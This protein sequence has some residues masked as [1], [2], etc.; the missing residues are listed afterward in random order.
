MNTGD[1]DYFY[2]FYKNS[3]SSIERIEK[4]LLR[5]SYSYDKWL[6]TLQEKSKTLRELYEKNEIGI[7]KVIEAFV[8]KYKGDEIENLT[9]P[10]AEEY[11]T[12]VDFFLSEGYRDYEVTVPVLKTLIRFYE[13]KGP[14]VR[15]LDCYYFYAVAML[16]QREFSEAQRYFSEVIAM[17][18]NAN[19][20]V[21]LYR[22]FRIMCSHYFR[23]LAAICED[24]LAQGKI[25]TYQNSAWQIWTVL[26]PIDFLN[27]RQRNAIASILRT[28]PG[29]TVLAVLQEKKEVLP[30]LFRIVE[31]EYQSQ[32][33]GRKNDLSVDSLIYLC[34]YKANFLH[35]DYTKK[36]YLR[37][38][39]KKFLHEKK[40]ID[41][42]YEYGT[43][44][45]IELF[46]DEL[47]EERVAKENL[48]YMN[49][50][51]SFV[52]FLIPEILEY[53]HDEKIRKTVYEELT[54]YYGGIPV[55]SGDFLTDFRIEGQ[56]K[57]LFSKEK[58]VEIVLGCLENI[59]VSR[60]VTT[61]IHSGM[62]SRLATIMTSRFIESS[63]DLFVGQCGTTC[64]E[65]VLQKKDEI[66][67]FAKLA[68][69]CHDYGKIWCS[70]IINLQER[71][72]VD[73]EFCM[74]KR[75]SKKGAEIFESIE[76]LRPFRDIAIG[77]HKFYD[78]SYG[79]PSHFDNV[80]SPVKIFIDII[81]LCDCIDAVTD[82]LGRNYAVGKDFY[83]VLKEF[84][85]YSGSRYS[86][87]LVELIG[88]DTEL[89]KQIQELT[90]N[91]RKNVYYE[92]YNKY[93][94]ADVLFRP[95]NEKIVRELRESDVYVVGKMTGEAKKII[96]ERM[97]KCEVCY[98][99][100]DGF[101]KIFGV[102]YAETLQDALW[103]RQIQVAES[104][105]RQ[106]IGSMLYRYLEEMVKNNGGGTIYMPVVVEGH[107]DKFCWRNGFVDSDV[108]GYMV[109]N[110]KK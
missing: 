98:L 29:Y 34:H 22:K 89:Q 99:V 70:D 84:E 43:M 93:V 57:R 26:P 69:R 24:T 35:G 94:K 7:K 36:E 105:R 90:I 81:T 60:Q 73:E 11:L 49:P 64:E 83:M 58:D 79:Y 103:I 41:G 55:N 77:H 85:R 72:I 63:P 37:I 110:V 17:F 8:D 50:G 19:M 2:N 76:A 108:E 54:T 28:L 82:K 75:H 62:V 92:I 48:P 20:C 68:G 5:E 42:R 65:E 38:L 104:E 32:T 100:Q 10:I 30:D 52:F 102:I 27:K 15:L 12:H 40:G 1:I 80:S 6:A 51:Y 56:I 13:K 71:R 47:P 16:E 39:K 25:L 61:I 18:P 88:S 78:G 31:E 45:F 95:K 107:Y 33:M 97:K 66:I 44:E 106:G 14:V 101:G 53:S 96:R 9:M 87:I 21:E 67:K 74:I 3:I 59:Y 91:E 4:K 86:D 109:K 46:D 23:L